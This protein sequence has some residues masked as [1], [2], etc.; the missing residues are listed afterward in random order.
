MQESQPFAFLND[1]MIFF[2]EDATSGT[3]HLY[4]EDFV[5]QWQDFSPYLCGLKSAKAS[6]VVENSYALPGLRGQTFP[7]ALEHTKQAFHGNTICGN[8]FKSLLRRLK[9]EDVTLNSVIENRWEDARVGRVTNQ[10]A[11]VMPRAMGTLGSKSML[12]G[13][14]YVGGPVMSTNSKE[15]NVTTEI[16]VS[17]KIAYDLGE[18]CPAEVT[19]AIEELKEKANEVGTI[20]EINLTTD[21][22]LDVDIEV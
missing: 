9:A 17:I 21:G 18:V 14:T 13:P 1:G 5:N 11:T 3:F 7:R 16:M 15:H 2:V 20:E 4:R 19:D 8:C 12:H 6:V 22:S 10:V